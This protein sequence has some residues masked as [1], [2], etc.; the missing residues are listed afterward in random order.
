MKYESPIY[1]GAKAMVNVKVF[2]QVH[3]NPNPVG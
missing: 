3:A 1:T 2:V